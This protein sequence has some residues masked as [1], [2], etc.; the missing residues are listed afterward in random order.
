M[1]QRPRGENLEKSN[2]KVVMNEELVQN[3]VLNELKNS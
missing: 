2:Q 1:S 3:G